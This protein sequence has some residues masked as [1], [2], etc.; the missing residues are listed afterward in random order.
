MSIINKKLST[1]KR[2]GGILTEF[3]PEKMISASV[4]INKKQARIKA[5]FPVK[6]TPVR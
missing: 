5:T 3:K 4:I 6:K 1:N 2:A